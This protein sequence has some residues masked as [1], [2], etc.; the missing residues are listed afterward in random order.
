MRAK[1]CLSLGLGISL[2]FLVLVGT[3]QGRNP[4]LSFWTKNLS[5]NEPAGET[6]NDSTQEI[7]VVGSTVHV[8]YWSHKADIGWRLYYRRS[9]DGGQ[10]WQ[11]PILLHDPQTAGGAADR[12]RGCKYL[13]VD[14]TTVHVAYAKYPGNNAI[15]MYRRSTNGGASFEA[16][17]QL[18]PAVGD[19]YWWINH[20][21]IAASNGKVTIA[22]QYQAY[23]GANRA[24]RLL[25]SADG[26]ATFTARTEA[27]S[28]HRY[29]NIA[30]VDLKRDNDRIW[31][32]Y[33]LDYEEPYGIRWSSA[34][35]LATSL[36]GG[37]SFTHNRC[38]TPSTHPD[39]G[40]RYL[41]YKVQAASYSPNLAVA[42]NNVYVVWTQ[43][44]GYYD[45]PSTIALYLRRS[46]DQGLTFAAPQKLAQNRLNG[47]GDMEVGQEAI[48]AL[49][50]YAYVVFLTSDGL[51]HFRRSDNSGASFYS[52][53]ELGSEAWWP[54]L[55]VDP[56]DGAKVHV[57]WVYSYR[58][59]NNGGA[60]FSNPVVLMPY[61]G[62]HAEETG[63]QMALGAGDSK[64]FTL[65]LKYYTAA[66]G[67]GDLDIFYRQLTPVPPS[68]PG[69]QALYTYSDGDAGRY[70]SMEVAGSA[71]LNLTSKITGEVWVKPQ[72]GGVTTGTT[73]YT[74]YI[75]AK[76]LEAARPFVAGATPTYALGTCDYGDGR[77]QA[78]AEI[79]TADGSFSVS[80]GYWNPVGLVPDDAWTHLAF[81]Y[82]ATA[83]GNNFKLYKN[84][85]LIAETHASGNLQTGPGNFYA[86]VW[87][88]WAQTELR[89]WNR[90]LSQAEIQA[91]MTRSLSGT[92]TGLNAYW[93]FNR[94]TKDLTGHGNDG[95]L[96]YQESYVSPGS[97]LE[98]SINYLLLN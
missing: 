26:G 32:L 25:N 21:Y 58:Y 54:N 48:A 90:V 14:G 50:N 74:K 71:W 52:R 24:L 53:Q 64:H 8:L 28:G 3:A 88:R 94:S 68:A 2:T 55:V 6:W 79:T 87:G 49:A 46:T 22:F 30:P 97:G 67:W 16:A 29:L 86:G 20:T 84:G 5:G 75:F 39:T 76:L 56:T 36:N 9:T 93:T 35:F 33:I 91:N 60:S 38:T 62:A 10:T 44:D 15:L 1:D 70:D 19:S 47:L 89:L 73:T 77:R 66:Y 81:T 13:A 18:D 45:D 37:S 41:T 27:D 96:L 57:C 92:E 78:V 17:R 31:L 98:G 63:V 82:D 42:G 34:L 11:P 69:K 72:A 4:E 80:A 61:G 40:G 83:A 12:Q 51:V 95:I 85:Q 43:N 7:A 23:D 59:S 65:P